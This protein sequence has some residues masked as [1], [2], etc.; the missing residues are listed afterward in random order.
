MRKTLFVEHEEPVWDADCRVTLHFDTERHRLME[1]FWARRTA[2]G[3]ALCNIP[4]YAD[5]MALG[6]VV[7]VDANMNITKVSQA[8]GRFVFRLWSGEGWEGR[9]YLTDELHRLGGT[10]DEGYPGLLSVDAADRR[11]AHDIYEY[12]VRL[13]H[14]EKMWCEITCWPDGDK[15]TLPL[16]TDDFSDDENE[17]QEWQHNYPIIHTDEADAQVL[18]RGF[19][20]S[21]PVVD[22]LWA[23]KVDDGYLVCNIPGLIADV[24]L[25]DVVEVDDQNHVVGVVKRSG[26]SWFQISFNTRLGIEENR[27]VVEGLAEMG[28]WFEG[29]RDGIICIDAAPEARDQVWSILLEREAKGDIELEIG[30]WHGEGPPR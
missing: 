28:G 26:R 21:R 16:T 2:E 30:Y 5:G 20:D 27:A 15:P 7:E 14:G 1:T 3:Y 19:E 4:T 22:K 18:M 11:V 29:S 17:V 12:I 24:A 25:A 13:Q 9:E 8:S 6:D 23:V 10:L